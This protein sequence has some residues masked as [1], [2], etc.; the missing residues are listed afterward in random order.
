M[1]ALTSTQAGDW[2]TGT[3][4]VGGVAPQAGDTTTIA[5]AV[6]YAAN[7]T[8]AYGTITINAGA[9]LIHQAGTTNL[10]VA[11]QVVV[12]GT[13]QMVPGS[14]LEFDQ[15]SSSDYGMQI[16]SGASAKFIAEGSVGN[17]ETTLASSASIGDTSFSVAS[18]TGIVAGDWWSLYKRNVVYSAQEDEGVIVHDVSGTTV[19]FRHFV[20]PV[21]TLGADWTAGTTITVDDSSVMEPN[22][23]IILGTGASRH[24]RTIQS[25][26]TATTIVVDSGPSAT[27]S[28]GTKIYQTGLEKAH[29]SGSVVRKVA[30]YLTGN[31]SAG[32]TQFNV[33]DVG[34]I[35]INDEIVISGS[36]TTGSAQAENRVVQNIV[37]TTITVSSAFTYAHKAG[38][39]CVRLTRDCRVVGYASNASYKY[40]WIYS[41]YRST[42]YTKQFTAKDVEFKGFGKSTTTGRQGIVIRGFHNNGSGGTLDL[43]DGCTIHTFGTK[44]DW[45][46]CWLYSEVHYQT[47]RN[48]VSYDNYNNF[49][50][51][52]QNDIGFF[53]NVGL[54]A[55]NIGLRSEGNYSTRNEIGYNFIANSASLAM[56]LWNKY[57]PGYGVHHMY[58]RDSQYPFGAGNNGLGGNIWRLYMDNN[59]YLPYSYELSSIFIL[60]SYLGTRTTD[61]AGVYRP[62][63]SGYGRY[64]RESS[65][66]SCVRMRRVNF[67][68]DNSSYI[69]YFYYHE[70]DETEKA[71]RA[72]HRDDGDDWAGYCTFVFLPANTAFTVKGT[73]KLNPNY[74]SGNSEYPKLIL[75][76]FGYGGIAVQTNLS[77]TA[78]A[79]ALQGFTTYTITGTTG[80]YDDLL[81]MGWITYN[82]T[83]KYGYW[84][85]PT[86]IEFATATRDS[87]INGTVNGIN[88]IVQSPGTHGITLAGATII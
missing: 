82:R 16:G 32:A 72:Y 81:N 20:T 28:T 59:Q 33:N 30:T 88:R 40:G 74:L 75:S 10:R 84:F 18:A 31:I 2:A 63:G 4:W 87:L 42:D 43:L 69:S 29:S 51:Y 71:Y 5:H 56:R 78:D 14:Q 23:V 68:R 57:E 21:M 52:Y 64:D 61:S 44:V 19:Y 35:Q 1:A 27:V 24:V 22:Y 54:G 15:T 65:E 36:N 11:G 85:K 80:K 3:T 38:D 58:L 62:I 70:W 26:P 17:V 25:I 83:T 86:V 8:T 12:N 46:G 39:I 48:C 50:L 45:G 60:D 37:G 6:T 67:K 76:S 53:N 13:Y 47:V 55:T 79:A 73:I 49:G 77:V 9:S 41:V 34:S 7:N 66:G